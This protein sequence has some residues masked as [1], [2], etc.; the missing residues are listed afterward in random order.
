MTFDSGVLSEPLLLFGGQNQHVDPK[1]GLSLYGPYLPT[2][3]ATMPSVQIRVG[4]VGPA[5]LAADAAQFLAACDGPIATHDANPYQSPGFPGFSNTTVFRTTLRTGPEW[6]HPFRQIELEKALAAN[7]G[8]ARVQA[9]SALYTDAISVLAERLPPP[10][11]VLCCISDEIY[12]KCLVG[13]SLRLRERRGLRRSSSRRNDSQLALF[14]EGDEDTESAF[15]DLW[16]AIKAAAMPYGIPTQLVRERSLSLNDRPA[17]G[18]QAMATR[19]WNLAVGLYH[20]SG[21]SPWRLA[22][23]DPGVC[24]VG[25]SFFR[26][27]R[28]GDM[29]IHTSVAQAFTAAGDGYVLRGRPFSSKSGIA[30]RSPH[31]DR[32]SASRLVEDVIEQYKRQ[33]RGQP[34]ARLVIHKS[35]MFW[36]EEKD[37][38]R[39]GASGIAALDLV[40]FRQRHIQLFRE[41]D[42]PP[43]RGTFVKFTT[44]NLL[45]YVKG[46]IPYF[47][48]YPGARAP[49]PIEIAEHFGD[50]SWRTVLGEILALTKMNWN[51]ADFSAGAP[52]TISFSRRV[53]ALLAEISPESQIRPEYRFYM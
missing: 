18:T 13:A 5:S 53:G 37:G 6:E 45:L 26:D 32:E 12:T 22:N 1:T 52:I 40:A 23:I 20:K 34:P 17:P 3:E 28:A 24:F 2:G 21:G 16:K 7:A 44:T 15:L 29:R 14:G 30:T 39:Q 42:Y 25:V 33:H 47:E 35:S 46:Y 19:A 48:T 11:V 38:M 4:I 31:M 41:G 51:S 50:S 36:D 10:D 9:V 27:A 43:L 8:S 49:Q